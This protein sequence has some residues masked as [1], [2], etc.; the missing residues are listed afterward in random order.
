VRQRTAESAE[1]NLQLTQK[2]EENEM[3]VYSVSHD[4]RTP[5]VNLQG[6]SQELSLVSDDLKSLLGG[7]GVPQELSSRGAAIIEGEMAESL[8]FIQNAVSHLSKII[9][10]LLRLSR[11]GRV[12]YQVRRVNL[13]EMVAR[14]VDAL[15]ATVRSRGAKVIVQDLPPTWGDPAALEQLFSNLISNALNYLDPKRPGLI[16]IGC[17]NKVVASE[18][19]AGQP[20][21][22]YYVRD[23]GLGLTDTEQGKIFRAFHRFHPEA[24]RGEGMGLAIVRRIV[25]RHNGRVWV[26]SEAGEGTTFYVMLAADMSKAEDGEESDE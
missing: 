16:E 2:T 21:L 10:A 13:N 22:A 15:G 17:I 12:V 14:I 26:E 20:L 18:G 1:R 7:E 11:A 24:A 19:E 23:N 6:F 5:L 25:E 9:D 8:Q 4:M 3:F